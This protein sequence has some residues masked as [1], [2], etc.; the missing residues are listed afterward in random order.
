VIPAIATLRDRFGI[1]LPDIAG[2][3]LTGEIPLSDALVNRLIAERLAN[4]PQVSS[5]RVQ[6]EEGDRVAVLVTPRSRLMPPVKISALVERQPEF[7]GAPV[8]RLHW[9]MPALGPLAML[10]APALAFFKALPPG[11]RVEG[12]R[13]FVDVRQLLESRGLG[14][15]VGMIRRADIHTRR[16]GF[17]VRFEVGV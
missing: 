11:I 17:V 3:T 10:A 7:P 8:L 1:D 14:E 4:H 9:T 12:D 15:V 5:V 2:T 16:G 13:L 6:A